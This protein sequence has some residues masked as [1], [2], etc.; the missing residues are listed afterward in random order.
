MEIRPVYLE[1]VE[2][3][4]KEEASPGL[5]ASPQLGAASSASKLP[6]KIPPHARFEYHEIWDF[7]KA[8]EALGKVSTYVMCGCAKSTPMLES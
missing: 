5:T 3:P 2:I 7:L 8:T 6:A 1:E 4:P